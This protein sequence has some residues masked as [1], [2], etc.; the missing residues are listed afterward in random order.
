MGVKLNL[1]L[2][3]PFII[4]ITIL[5]P[6]QYKLIVIGRPVVDILFGETLWKLHI[7]QSQLI[8]RGEVQYYNTKRS[9]ISLIAKKYGTVVF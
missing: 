4:L 2:S 6:L 8:M 1:T 7:Q 3:I 9:L 5:I